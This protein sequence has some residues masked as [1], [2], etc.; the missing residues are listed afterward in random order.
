VGFPWG[1]SGAGRP[2][3]ELS[4]CESGAVENEAPGG[5]VYVDVVP[6]VVEPGDTERSFDEENMTITT[7]SANSPKH[8]NPRMRPRLGRE[9]RTGLSAPQ[10][11][12]ALASVLTSRPHS[13]HGLNGIGPFPPPNDPAH[14][15]RAE[16]RAAEFYGPLLARNI[17][18]R[19]SLSGPRPA[20]ACAC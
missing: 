4:A 17:G 12:Q 15:L 20:A 16:A 10:C 11:G 6:V 18:R 2:D 3:V 1:G 7:G 14:Q 8:P 19:R 5:G 9:D 13:R